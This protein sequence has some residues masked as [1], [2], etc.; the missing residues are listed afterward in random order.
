MQGR[1][2][3]E[4]KIQKTI[5]EVLKSMPEFANEWYLNMRASKK[6]ASS[7]LDYARKIRRFLEYIS[8]NPINMKASEIT[9]SACESYCIS[10]QTKTNDNGL[11]VYTSDSYQQGIWSALNS[12]MKF[13]KKRGYIEYNFMEDID[14]PKNR[15]LDRINSERVL[16]TQDDF[17]RILDA[18]K[19]GSDFKDG[20]FNSRDTLIILLFMTTGMRK[21]ALS[22]INIDDIDFKSGSLTVID[23]GNKIHVYRLHDQVS[24]YAR[25]WINDS[26]QLRTYKSGDALFV[27]RYG[28]RL[29]PYGIWEI[30][31]KYCD[32][33]IDKKL[34]PHKLR[35]GFCSILY[36]KTHDI[37]FV[38]RAVGHSSIKTTQRYIKT[39]EKEK[40]RAVEIMSDVLKI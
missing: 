28:D 40:E 3:N 9:L 38:R 6:T 14:K 34:S 10:C 23:K 35:A 18:A 8:D 12:F 19:D 2:E 31:R 5:D 15:D 17:N 7:C 27:N 20:I 32:K 16:L 24:K 11:I 22:E 29:S 37:E 1:L 25:Q 4:M 36:D 30:V 26:K 33:A 13:L 39:N 21:T